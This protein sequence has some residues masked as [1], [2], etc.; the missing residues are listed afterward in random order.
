MNNVPDK[1]EKLMMD[2]IEFWSSQMAPKRPS[3]SASQRLSSRSGSRDRDDPLLTAPPAQ[4]RA[5]E[6]N[7]PRQSRIAIVLQ[8]PAHMSKSSWSQVESESG[9]GNMA[10]TG[11]QRAA[12]S[13]A[14]R[15]KK[16]T[17]NSNTSSY[18]GGNI[19]GSSYT[20]TSSQTADKNTNPC[21]HNCII[22]YNFSASSSL[23]T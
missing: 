20:S 22:N 7:E 8:A 17:P 5:A 10:A 4:F 16:E 12:P 19:G 23:S 2:P 9:S 11:S 14:S 21:N 15:A 6:K 3:S 18:T 13:L 1:G